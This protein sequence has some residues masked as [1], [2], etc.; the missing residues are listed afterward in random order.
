MLTPSHFSFGPA[1]I[2]FHSQP[3]EAPVCDALF[4]GLVVYWTRFI[5]GLSLSISG[6]GLGCLRFSGDGRGECP[7]EKQKEVSV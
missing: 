7:F 6:P 4:T 3:K 2:P 1:V 5:F